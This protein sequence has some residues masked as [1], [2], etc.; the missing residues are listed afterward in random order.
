MLAEIDNVPD[1][2]CLYLELLELK[3]PALY[4]TKD[5]LIDF[6]SRHIN[7]DVFISCIFIDDTPRNVEAA[8]KLG[9]C[10]IDFHTREQVLQE[11]AA[12][13]VNT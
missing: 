6:L 7:R 13:G 10:G 8:R 12:L 3:G 2:A 4:D 5:M 11:M 1:I 9:I